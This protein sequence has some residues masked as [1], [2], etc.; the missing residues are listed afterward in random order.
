MGK[1]KTDKLSHKQGQFGA[2]EIIA[3]IDALMVKYD[4]VKDG[5][6]EV[7][8]ETRDRWEDP[9]YDPYDDS[10]MM[11]YAG[12]QSSN[13]RYYTVSHT[14]YTYKAVEDIVEE[15]ISLPQICSKDPLS[16]FKLYEALSVILK[17]HQEREKGT[18]SC[19]VTKIFDVI[20]HLPQILFECLD[21]TQFA[22]YIHAISEW[23]NKQKI[24]ALA[25]E[26]LGKL[27][28]PRAIEPLLEILKN[29]KKEMVQKAAAE[30][31]VK[32]GYDEKEIEY[33]SLIRTLHHHILYRRL[34]AA[35]ALGK[36]GDPRAVELLLGIW[37]TDCE[38]SVRKAAGEALAILGY[39]DIKKIEFLTCIADINDHNFYARQ[40]GAARLG[41]LGDHRA[42]EP[43]LGILNDDT[44]TVRKAAAEALVTLGY[45]EK[46]IKVLSSIDILKREGRSKLDKA[47]ESL[48]ELGTPFAIEGLAECLRWKD[49]TVNF[50]VARALAELGDHR[51]VEPLVECLKDSSR[52]VH[53]AKILVELGD[54]RAMPPLLKDLTTGRYEWDRIAAAEALGKLGDPRALPALKARVN[55]K[56]LCCFWCCAGEE[57]DKRVIGAVRNA[58]AKIE[59]NQ[60]SPRAVAMQI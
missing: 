50:I 12:P 42:I 25:V 55:C 52:D 44:E 14:V 34:A 47:V 3:K 22:V 24:R 37:K 9:D 35:N 43:L 20:Q 48:V 51:P 15:L 60:D 46:K 23:K 41:E 30:A 59:S 16:L 56:F 5:Q 11:R 45:D 2:E 21:K 49:G 10:Y 6:K 36:L 32:L 54:S 31:L 1:T 19:I 18:S 53:A 4:R 58:I 28:N 13:S 38:R 27:G 7:I 17:S 29:D 40:E 8:E 26:A 33:L 57:K 39:D